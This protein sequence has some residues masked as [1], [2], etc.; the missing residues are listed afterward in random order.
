MAEKKKSSRKE[1]LDL[2]IKQED[3]SYVYTGPRYVPL[4]TEWKRVS[5]MLYL[6]LAAAAV[7][8]IVAGMVPSRGMIGAWYVILPYAASVVMLIVLVI[9]MIRV[10]T[11]KGTIHSYTYDRTVAW[12]SADA[13]IIMI[14]NA[15]SMAG[16]VIASFGGEALIQWQIVALIVHAA[17]M[18][19]LYQFRMISG[20]VQWQEEGTKAE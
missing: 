5:R 16:E 15:V 1:Y 2:F 19:F 18:F 20:S 9:R 6:Y 8:L 12:F 14:L 11:D 3:G 17:A 4:N 13:V 10:T 7:C